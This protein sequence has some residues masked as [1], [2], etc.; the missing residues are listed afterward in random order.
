MKKNYCEDFVFS[1]LFQ[2]L[3]QFSCVT[4]GGLV[5]ELLVAGNSDGHLADILKVKDKQPCV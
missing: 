5:A 2:T 3:N 1:L 4:L